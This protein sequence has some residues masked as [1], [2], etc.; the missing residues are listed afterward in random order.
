ME[1]RDSLTKGVRGLIGLG[2]ILLLVMSYL[3]QYTDV[4]KAITDAQFREEAHFIANRIFRILFNDIGMIMVI[5]AIFVDRQVLRLALA[6]QLIDLFILLPVYL[7]LKLP[8]EGTSELSSPFL[9]QLHRIIVNPI[10][11]ILLIPALYYQ[12]NIKR[13]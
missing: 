12:R 13:P 6:V 7:L 3:F 1:S 5:Y 10:L 11:M 9:S 2:G 4:L 8:S